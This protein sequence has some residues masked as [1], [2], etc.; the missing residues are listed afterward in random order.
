MCFFLSEKSLL[1][2]RAE[3]AQRADPDAFGSNERG[4]RVKAQ[5]WRAGNHWGLRKPGVLERFL[6]SV[7]LSRGS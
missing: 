5:M 7:Q 4:A 6:L 3:N 2:L 1:R